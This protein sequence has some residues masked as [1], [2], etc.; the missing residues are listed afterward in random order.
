M[1]EADVRSNNDSGAFAAL[2]WDE[3]IGRKRSLDL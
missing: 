3:A 2:A 1:A